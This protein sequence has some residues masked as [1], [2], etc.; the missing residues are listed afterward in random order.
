MSTFR[1]ALRIAAR[2]PIYI[3][4]YLVGLSLMG[5]LVMTSAVGDATLA[6]HDSF[7]AHVAIVDRDGSALSRALRDVVAEDGQVVEV[8]DSEFALQDALATSQAD[9]IVV[10]PEG[11][12][13]SFAQAAREGGELPALEMASGTR[14]DT[15]ALVEAELSSWMRLMGAGMAL[16]PDASVAEVAQDVADA[17]GERAETRVVADEQAS[18]GADVLGSYLSFSSY[19]LCSSVIVCAGVVFCSLGGRQVRR[20][21]LAGPV[22]ERA[23]AVGSLAAGV[24]MALVA[25]AVVCGVGIAGLMPRL[26]DLAASQIALATLPMLAYALVPLALAFL[27]SQLSAS[28]QAINAIG[29][30]FG[31]VMSFLGGAWV[32]LDVVGEGVQAAARLCPCFWMTDAI[33]SALT[34]PDAARIAAD[35]AIVCLFA[36]ALAAVGMVVGRARRQARSL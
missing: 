3:G 12:G 17:S 26:S 7:D 16:R 20:R 9:C 31:M 24:V 10:V 27:L 23:V 4:I 15:A 14:Q 1:A 13:E 8:G 19:A 28:E 36:A 35:I 18:S 21:T 6:E 5:L 34:V 32:P 11:F 25:W 22:P 29:N 33:G 2:H 30:I